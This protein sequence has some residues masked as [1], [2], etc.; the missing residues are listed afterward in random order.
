MTQP[1]EQHLWEELFMDRMPKGMVS[2]VEEIA[3]GALMA[4]GICGHGIN[5]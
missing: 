2:V 3:A 4:K 1:M 5:I